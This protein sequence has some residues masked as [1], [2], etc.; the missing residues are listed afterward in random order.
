MAKT[1]TEKTRESYLKDR[2]NYLQSNIRRLQE[3]MRKDGMTSKRRTKLQEKLKSVK[4]NLRKI[5]SESNIGNTTMSKLKVIAT[6]AQSKQRNLVDTVTSATKKARVERDEVDILKSIKGAKVAL[7]NAK[8]SGDKDMISNAK[9][10]LLG[11]EDELE[12]AQEVAESNKAPV[13][14]APTKKAP[15]SRTTRQEP[16]APETRPVRKSPSSPTKKAPTK[17]TKGND[18]LAL[19]ANKIQAKRELLFSLD[20]SRGALM[21]NK[22]KGDMEAASKS[23][24]RINSLKKKLAE[25]E[26]VSA[27]HTRETKAWINAQPLNATGLNA[28]KKTTIEHA[29]V[30]TTTTKD[31]PSQTDSSG[32]RYT[33]VGVNKMIKELTEKQKRGRKDS[34]AFKKREEDIKRLHDIAKGLGKKTGLAS[35]HANV[36]L[37][38]ITTSHSLE[39]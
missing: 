8:K 20:A 4:D 14:K 39:D 9:Q 17:K 16:P 6:D 13:K 23:Q 34:A 19:K 24:R 2:S 33:K 36:E 21:S 15:G 11:Y 5:K 37:R 32:K 25:Y 22:K 10:K 28:F 1:D 7:Q 29:P 31:A 18:D 30:K 38:Q 35:V 27:N 26:G 3:E 12:Y